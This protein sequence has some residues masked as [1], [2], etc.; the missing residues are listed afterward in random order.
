MASRCLL[1]ADFVVFGG[2]GQVQDAAGAGGAAAEAAKLD[3]DA[4]RQRR[5]Q[6]EGNTTDALGLHARPCL[7]VL[8]A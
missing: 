2:A 3:G 5:G 1:M 8:T 4:H 6:V 7:F